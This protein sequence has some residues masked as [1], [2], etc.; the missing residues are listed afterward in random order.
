M[1]MSLR[2]SFSCSSCSEELFRKNQVPT[3]KKCIK[4]STWDTGWNYVPEEIAQDIIRISGSFN[5]DAVIGRVEQ[6]EGKKLTIRSSSE[7][8]YIKILCRVIKK[9]QSNRDI[10]SVKL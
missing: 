3:G 10:D 6:H 5:I 8:L 2:Q 9:L 7:N 4:Y 1:Y